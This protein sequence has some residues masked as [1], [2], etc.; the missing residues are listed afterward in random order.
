MRIQNLLLKIFIIFC[1]FSCSSKK[2]VLLLQDL[3]I[4][5]VYSYDFNDPK[6]KKGDIL[7]IN[8]ITDNI[9]SVES[10]NSS[11]VS[12]FNENRE[13]LILK[14]YNVDESGYIDF[15]KLGKI[16]VE[17]LSVEEL[18][19]LISK[20]F[21]ENEIF[22]SPSVQIRILNLNFTVIGEVNNPG[23]YYYN[24]TN[25]NLLQALGTAGDITIFGNR[26]NIKLLRNFENKLKTYDID[27]TKTNFINSNAFKIQSGDIIIVNPN[28]S[29]VKN[30]G[31]IGNSGTLLSLLSFLLSSIIVIQN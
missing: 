1:L 29:R 15:P 31:I 2:D 5:D 3:E 12:T 6:I 30:A 11:S 22:T 21:I 7:K 8:V 27:L 25:L 26:K 14:G 17:N 16:Y 20:R 19:K 23:K 9:K 18:S 13:S 10:I 24:E 4:N 28:S